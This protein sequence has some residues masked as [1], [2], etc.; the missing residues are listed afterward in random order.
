MSI[1]LNSCT[2][3]P[4]LTHPSFNVNAG[5]PALPAGRSISSGVGE[6]PMVMSTSKPVV[7]AICSATNRTRARDTSSI[8]VTPA[9]R[10]RITL[11]GASPVVEVA[12]SPFT[13]VLKAVGS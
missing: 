3:T 2:A 9:T 8:P 11:I 4:F 1:A 12:A 10:T 5:R 7:R 6:V 13:R